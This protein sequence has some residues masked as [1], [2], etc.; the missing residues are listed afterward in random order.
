MT[1]IHN[2][3]KRHLSSMSM[4]RPSQINHGAPL[5]KVHQDILII[6]K[7]YSLWSRNK[8]SF[9]FLFTPKAAVSLHSFVQCVYIYTSYMLKITT[10]RYCVVTVNTDNHDLTEDI[11]GWTYIQ[12]ME[13]P[14]FGETEELR[15]CNKVLVHS[16]FL[17]NCSWLCWLYER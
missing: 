11:Q 1:E 7:S 5:F 17:C 16:C 12:M 15:T 6:T 2:R 13:K 3:R 4:R 10:F 9:S 8:L 14:D